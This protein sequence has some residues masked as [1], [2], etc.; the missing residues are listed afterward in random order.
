MDAAALMP[1]YQCVK[2]ARACKVKSL[3]RDE[4]GYLVHPAEPFL[5]EP[6]SVP[7]E[8]INRH[9]IHPGNYLLLYENGLFGMATARDFEANWLAVDHLQDRQQT[10]IRQLADVTAAIA[11]Q[12]RSAT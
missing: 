8:F 10:L 11:A 4:Q 1:A 3:E 9:Q 6:I 2:R 5:D 7:F 12:Q